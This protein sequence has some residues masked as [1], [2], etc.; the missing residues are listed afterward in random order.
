M[1]A[2]SQFQYCKAQGIR[3]MVLL[4]A[5]YRPSKRI[6]RV[7]DVLSKRDEAVSVTQLPD[8]IKPQ[9]Q[10]QQDGG[11][12]SMARTASLEKMPPRNLT[13]TLDPAIMILEKKAKGGKA[14]KKL[15][16]EAMRSVIEF[17]QTLQLANATVLVVE[18]PLHVLQSLRPELQECVC[19]R[20][21]AQIPGR[22]VR[23]KSAILKLFEYL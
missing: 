6:V 18:A 19:T 14:R 16:D 1:T 3:F 10:K 22:H 20:S 13:S 4:R 12:A 5:D 2:E 7:K 15:A 9:L 23:Y 11:S 17:C 8:Y 21:C